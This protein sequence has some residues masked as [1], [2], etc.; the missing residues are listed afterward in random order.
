MNQVYAGVAQWT[1]PA[2]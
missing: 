2:A 1:R